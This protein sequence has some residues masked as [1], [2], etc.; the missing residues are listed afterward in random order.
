GARGVWHAPLS[1][2][3]GAREK[4]R[5][6]DVPVGPDAVRAREGAAAGEP[7]PPGKPLHAAPERSRGP[8]QPSSRVPPPSLTFEAKM[9]VGTEQRTRDARLLLTD[10]T[11][12]VRSN[13]AEKS[14]W[15][16]VAYGSV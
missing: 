16:S 14:L 6:V 12:D 5:G 7:L 10:K 15:Y 8:T 13:D 4:A 11:V 2:E 1:R 3:A 9:L